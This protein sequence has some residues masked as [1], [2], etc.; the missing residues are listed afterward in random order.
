MRG[1]YTAGV[2]DAFLEAD[3]EFSSVYG[4]SAGSCHACSY[5][6]KQYK[7]AYR[8]NVDY[9]KDPR[10]CSVKSLLKTGDLFG[11]D[12]LYSQIPDVLDPF[13]HET[14]RKYPGKFYAVLTNV[15][16][17]KAEY[18]HIKDL[19]SQIWAVRASSSLPLISRTIVVKGRP[20]LDGGI[21]DSIPIRRSIKD[22]NKK[23]VVILTRE[24]G[25][26]KGPNSMMPLIRL[27]YP[28]SKAFTGKMADRYIRYNETLEFLER[29][30]AAGHIFLIRPQKK[31][32]VGRIEKDRTKLE[33][34][35]QAGLMDGRN[36]M[37]IMKRYLEA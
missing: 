21:A 22:G 27:R 18:I 35:Y 34:L 4:V 15:N 36:A 2:L 30:E 31:V 32:E 13:D 23:N 20:Y 1:V 17:G 9:L 8:V 6:S 12:M 14:F 25:Y 26:R 33:V 5:L 24:E 29:E 16:T 37:E 7:R 11:A 28:R 19:A 3:I 10:Y